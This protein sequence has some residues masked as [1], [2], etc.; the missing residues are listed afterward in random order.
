MDEVDDALD[1]VKGLGGALLR[2]KVVAEAARR[3]VLIGDASKRVTRLGERGPVPVEVL[4]F[5]L[6]HTAARL[7]ALGL[8][9]RL[10][11]GEAAP[12]R[13]DNGHPILDCAGA[14]RT[15]PAEL[16]AALDRVPGVVGHGLFLG[17][18]DA[19]YLAGADGVAFRERGT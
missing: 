4:A 2:E 12:A 19:A 9:P 3:F 16:A 8:E 7:E 14:D 17:V 15:D 1:A 10:R 6:R 11:G 5:G 18:A 13:S